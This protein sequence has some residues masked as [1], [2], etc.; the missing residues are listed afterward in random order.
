MEI[1]D[2]CVAFNGKNTDV[3]SKVFFDTLFEQCNMT[4]VRLHIV[5]NGQVK[6]LVD[7]Q[8]NKYNPTWYTP[9]GEIQP[10]NPPNDFYVTSILNPWT[11]AEWML[12]NCGKFQW[13]VISHF[14][15]LF[16]GDVLSWMR[17]VMSDN[18]AIVGTHCPIMAINRKLYK[19][20]RVGFEPSTNKDVGMLL[21]EDLQSQ[22]YKHTKLDMKTMSMLLH[23]GGGA[24]Y[25]NKEEFDHMRRRAI[26]APTR[27]YKKMDQ[28]NVLG[29][30]TTLIHYFAYEKIFVNEKQT[31]MRDSWRSVEMYVACMPNMTEFGQTIH[32]QLVM[33]TDC[34]QAVTCPQCKKTDV[35]HRALD[36]VK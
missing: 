25:H 26:A 2:Y 8:V 3:L 11:M 10:T 36:R 14:D 19:N 9:K 6:E 15:M 12:E 35:Y 1:V 30:T 7:K 28:I 4:N 31:M 23:F 33:R 32:H 21:E 29:Q 13:C 20:R 16:T 34:V 18:T 17:S 24:S 27:E 5:D 22:G